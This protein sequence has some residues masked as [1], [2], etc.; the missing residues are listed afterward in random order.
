MRT[1]WVTP[2]EGRAFEVKAENIEVTSEVCR[3]VKG[4]NMT[5]AVIPLGNLRF[6]IEQGN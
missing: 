2:K 4:T 1:F 5:V 6:V 3:F